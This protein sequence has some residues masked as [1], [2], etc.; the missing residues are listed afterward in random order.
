[1]PIA[2][3]NGA[4]C[5]WETAQEFACGH[6]GLYSE[7]LP[8]SGSMRNGRL[9][10]PQTQEAAIS[11]SGSS[12]LPGRETLLPTPPAGNFNDGESLESWTRRRDKNLAKGVNGNGMGTPLSIA[13][14]K[15]AGNLLPT[16]RAIDGRA[17]SNGPR[18]DTVT[19]MF[20]YDDTGRR[21]EADERVELMGTPRGADGMIGEDLDVTNVMDR[22]ARPLNEVIVNKLLPTP[23]VADVTGGHATRSGS[24]S[25]EMLL[26][27]VA[28]VIG[29]EANVDWGL[30]ARAVVRWE[31]VLGRLV[32][33]PLEP[34]R[35]GKGR[36]SAL[37]VEW[38]MGLP[39]GWV[40][41]VPD[42]SRN[43]KLKALG[44]GVVPQEAVLGIMLLLERLAGV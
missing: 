7:T 14:Q 40:C 26:P 12:S 39:E 20:L 38:M 1:M 22:N 11:A 42:L 32:P 37:F 19:G 23:Q 8:R 6:L 9:Y 24:R 28:R 17:K 30:Y 43:A 3:W 16:P 35:A 18:Q 15:V 21:R 27:G 4:R 33:H 13:I 44:N 5:A 31:H 25:G 2:T 34:G 10:R 41:D 36:L 29:R